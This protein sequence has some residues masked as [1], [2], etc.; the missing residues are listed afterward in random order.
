VFGKHILTLRAELAGPVD[1]AHLRRPNNFLFSCF[2]DELD[3]A[4]PCG[5]GWVGLRVQPTSLC[6]QRGAAGCELS[7]RPACLIKRK[8]KQIAGY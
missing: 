2:K 4:H 1:Q 6:Y 7:S 5:M 8:E 3:P